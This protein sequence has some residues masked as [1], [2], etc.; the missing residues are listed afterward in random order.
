MLL[1]GYTNQIR[2]L[3]LQSLHTQAGLD[4]QLPT[5]AGNVTSI[6][7]VSEDA[8]VWS[9]DHSQEH[10]V[11]V[12]KVAKVGPTGL[13]TSSLLSVAASSVAVHSTL[14]QDLVFWVDT[15]L[16]V[17]GAVDVNHKNPYVIFEQGLYSPR[18]LVVYKR[19]RWVFWLCCWGDC[20]M[21]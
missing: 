18:A 17:I 4:F 2:V 13:I 15:A 21:L 19:K 9:E 12:I 8:V 1:V 10:G 20:V 6:A 16:G 14:Y 11:G 5:E 7:Y 3:V